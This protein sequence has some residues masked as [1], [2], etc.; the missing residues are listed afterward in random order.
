[1]SG[2]HVEIPDLVVRVDAGRSI[3]PRALDALLR[4]RIEQ[5]L[6][7]RSDEYVTVAHGAEPRVDTSKLQALVMGAI[8][9]AVAEDDR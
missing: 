1:V 7:E 5:A 9:R 6:R 2:R 3:S 8:E 4:S